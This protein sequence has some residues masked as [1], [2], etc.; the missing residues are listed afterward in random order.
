M[1]NLRLVN[2]STTAF[3]E[4]NFA[5]IT[6]LTDDEIT[7]VIAPIVESER[8]EDGEYDNDSLVNALVMCYPDNFI[9][10]VIDADLLTI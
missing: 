2:I 5:L 8:N 1:E 4:E 7:H 3:S 10:C 9:Q 6:N